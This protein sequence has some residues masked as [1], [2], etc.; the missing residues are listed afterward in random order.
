MTS[1]TEKYIDLLLKLADVKPA[2]IS[3]EEAEKQRKEIDKINFFQIHPSDVQGASKSDYV[4]YGKGIIGPP[5][6]VTDKDRIQ[7][8]K[9]INPVDDNHPVVPFHPTPDGYHDAPNEIGYKQQDGTRYSP[10]VT[11]VGF[12]PEDPIQD[13]I[14]V[15]KQHSVMDFYKL[16]RQIDQLLSTASYQ[17]FLQLAAVAKA[18]G[19][20]VNMKNLFDSTASISAEDEVYGGGGAPQAKGLIDQ[21]DS[22]ARQM[23]MKAYHQGLSRE[24][25]AGSSAKMLGMVDQLDTA[26]KNTKGMEAGALDTQFFPKLHAVQSELSK[27]IPVDIAPQNPA[28]KPERT[29]TTTVETVDP[30]APQENSKEAPIEYPG[31]PRD[32]YYAQQGIETQLS[33]ELSDVVKN[34]TTPKPTRYDQKGQWGTPTNEDHWKDYLNQK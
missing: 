17:A 31:D 20:L 12:G 1:K 14:K 9:D 30:T 21:L 5:T 22:I 18:T 6:E 4:G 19:A 8:E 2:I 32:P 11:E 25:M 27:V 3:P 16:A 33:P 7:F 23:Y 26:A 29:G 10:G 15:V 28:V 34:L 13:K 24:E